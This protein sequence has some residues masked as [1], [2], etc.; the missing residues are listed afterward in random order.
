M[1]V[2]IVVRRRL[3][4]GGLAVVVVLA[5]GVGAARADLPNNDIVITPVGYIQDGTPTEVGSQQPTI[6]IQFNFGSQTNVHVECQADSGPFTSCGTQQTANCPASQCWVYTPTYSSDGQHSLG[7]AIFDSSQPDTAP[8][9]PLDQLNYE[10]HIDSTPPDT[11]LDPGTLQFDS[12]HEGKHA[13][14]VSYGVQPIDDSDPILYQDDVKCAIT[15]GAPPA[16]WGDCSKL[17]V[18]FTTRSFRFWA[19]A[20]DP[21]GRPDP[22]PAESPPFS[23]IPCRARLLSHPRSLTQIGQQGLR[24]RVTCVQPT[25][26]YATL[27]IPVKELNKL[28]LLDPQVDSQDLGHLSGRTTQQG[29]SQVVTLHLLRRIPAFLYAYRPLSL[30]LDTSAATDHPSVI[31]RV[32]GR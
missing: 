1:H 13:I 17:R 2:G 29:Q 28:N 10:L 23:P 9:N 25:K 22:T 21:L 15:S 30:D 7:A 27:Q 31:H 20:V 5:W 8:G 4:L 26:Y 11:K 19:R 32:T 16:T 12:D 3:L 24:L 6:N 14:A 18:P